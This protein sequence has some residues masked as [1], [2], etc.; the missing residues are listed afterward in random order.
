MSEIFK[1]QIRFFVRYVKFDDDGTPLR[2]TWLCSNTNSWSDKRTWRLRTSAK[3][4]HDFQ[5]SHGDKAQ[6]YATALGKIVKV[7]KQK[8]ENGWK[9]E[10]VFVRD[11]TRRTMTV[12]TDNPMAAIAIAALDD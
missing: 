8:L 4:A 7:G 5:E 9:L 11:V 10:I 6:Q 3:Y 12:V 1:E 2:E